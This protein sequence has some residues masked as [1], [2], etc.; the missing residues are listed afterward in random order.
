[1]AGL[2][3][4]KKFQVGDYPEIENVIEAVYIPG[5]VTYEAKGNLNGTVTRFA[6]YD[7]AYGQIKLTVQPTKE[8]IATLKQISGDSSNQRFTGEITDEDNLSENFTN[9]GLDNFNSQEIGSND[10]TVMFSADPLIKR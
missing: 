2:V 4:K 7:N 5:G 9:V 3:T 8:T 10:F 1:M 6:N